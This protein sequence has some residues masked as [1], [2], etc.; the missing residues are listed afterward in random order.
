MYTIR[1]V[2]NK[3]GLDRTVI[4]GFQ[5]I[6]VQRERLYRHENIEMDVTESDGYVAAGVRFQWLKIVDNN[7]FGTLRAGVVRKNGIKVEY[8]KI[9]ITIGEGLRGNL[10]NKT[11]EEYKRYISDVFVYLEKEYGVKTDTEEV[12]FHSMEINVTIPLN[13]DFYRYHR[14]LQLMMFN[15]PNSF[16]KNQVMHNANKKEMRLETETLQRSNETT[17]VKI[18][19]KK[20]QLAQTI[21]YETDTEYMRIEF[22]LKNAQKI[23]EVF[24]TRLVCD[25][26]D[27]MVNEFYMKQ[28]RRL[29]VK[30]YRK[31]QEKN[32]V[33][34]KKMIRDSKKKSLRYWKSN[35]IREC[36]NREQADQIPILLDVKDLLIQVKALD[37]AGHYKRTADGIR[38]Q[39]VK[40]DVFL[41]NDAE[42]VE[43]IFDRVYE[44]YAYDKGVAGLETSS[45]EMK[46][47]V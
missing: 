12:K 16:K 37:T 32:A 17:A 4:G 41:Q 9:E 22:V 25:I 6:E 31:W 19:D 36:A 39:C 11:M 43:E 46:N 3:I 21:R 34:L 45:G 42:K 13:E 1:E 29:F 2:I 15:L 47:A 10:Q 26:T 30:P 20:R 5:I 27:F 40:N 23:K 33:Y 28:F 18:Y 8:A 7:K 14:V 24:H 38:K 35:L 44:A